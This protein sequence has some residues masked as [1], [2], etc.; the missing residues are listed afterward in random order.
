MVKWGGDRRRETQRGQVTCP[1]SRSSRF[2][3]ANRS[4]PRSSPISE[5]H[6][7]LSSC[8]G[9]TLKPCLRFSPTSAPSP[10]DTDSQKEA[11]G[12]LPSCFRIRQ[13]E[14][15]SEESYWALSLPCLKPSNA[16]FPSVLGSNLS[17]HLMAFAASKPRPLT[18][19]HSVGCSPPLAPTPAA[20]GTLS[21]SLPRGPRTLFLLLRRFPRPFS[22]S[23]SS[24]V[25]TTIC[26]YLFT[27]YRFP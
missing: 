5:W 11:V 4:A 17:C 20:P 18:S 12:C 1:R 26:N 13:P 3:A 15:L 23:V 19:L 7:P 16:F 6:H 14:H 24:T 9:T 2:P 10:I 22:H 8:S 21:S 25:F 27:S